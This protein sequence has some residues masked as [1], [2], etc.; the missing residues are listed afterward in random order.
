MNDIGKYY[1]DGTKFVFDDYFN[2]SLDTIIFSDKLESITF[3]CAFNQSLSCI[4]FPDTITYI[5]FG[6]AFDQPIIGTRF[7][8]NLEFLKF[9]ESFNQPI[10]A[11]NAIKDSSNSI[12]NKVTFPETLKSL[13]F[14]K[15]FNQSLKNI[16][17]TVNELFIGNTNNITDIPDCINVI[18]TLED[19]N[20]HNYHILNNLS[21]RIMGI[22]ITAPCP[23]EDIPKIHIDNLPASIKKIKIMYDVTGYVLNAI[24]RIPY[25][26]IIV[27]DDNNIL[28]C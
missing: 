5:E 24:T 4:K 18:F 17:H 21:P 15:N 7:P 11:L 9:G 14:G 16:P 3:G 2:K 28:R 12:V 1:C 10:D 8:T 13:V 23:T 22:A 27:D 26:C 6:Y 20:E 19:I 25:G